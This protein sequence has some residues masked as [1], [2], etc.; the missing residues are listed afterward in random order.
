MNNLTVVVTGASS[1]I[2]RE[3]VRLL[4]SSGI[5]TI[6]VAR[7]GTLLEELAR[8]CETACLPYAADVTDRVACQTLA[9]TIIEDES[10]TDLCLVNC[11]GSATFGPF[12]DMDWDLITEQIQTNMIGTLAP[13]HALLPLMIAAERGQI[14]NI[15][16]VAATHTFGGAVAYGAA[17]GGMLMATRNLAKEVRALGIRVTALMPGSTDTPIWDDAE[18]SPDR[19]DMLTARAVAEAVVDLVKMPRDRTVDEILLMPPKGVL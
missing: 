1:G 8:D 4:S 9:D 2:G 7:R 15:L 16:S 17:K 13:I 3:T 18:W 10:I 6:A 12:G 11:A 5:R 14:I 19:A